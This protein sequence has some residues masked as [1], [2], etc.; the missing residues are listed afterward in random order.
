MP[1]SRVRRFIRHGMLP[2]LAVFEAVCRLGSYTRAAEELFIAQPTVSTQMKKLS[3][4]IGL[5]LV[6]HNGRRLQ[7]T[8]AGRELAAACKDIFGR[9]EAAEE[10]LAAL[11]DRDH[12]RV[13]VA[14]R[15]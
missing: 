10:R 14:A 7:M 12:G 3:D 15:A 5:P 6:E 11:R 4:A 8:E 2:Q 13:H 1:R 9:L